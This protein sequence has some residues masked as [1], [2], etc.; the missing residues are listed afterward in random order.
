MKK[1]VFSRHAEY[2]IQVLSRHQV[3]VDKSLIE[4]I[5]SKPGRVENGYKNRLI[6]QGQLDEYHV[7]RIVYEESEEE[8]KIITIYP[9][10]RSRYEKD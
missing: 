1:I 8:I 5:I 2:K 9:G 10:R 3:N 7:L 6:A 4:K